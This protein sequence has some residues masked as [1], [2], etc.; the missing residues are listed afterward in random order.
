MYLKILF[1]VCQCSPLRFAMYR[2]TA[3]IAYIIFVLVHIITNIK[4]PI[5]DAYGT[6][7]IFFPSV[8]LLEHIFKDKINRKW[9]RNWLTILYVQ[10]HQDFLQGVLLR[11][12]NLP[13]IFVSMNLHP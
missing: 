4:L 9:G 12:P 2:L 11:K 7:D 3:R 1:T 8:S 13:V 5:I 10:A 6:R